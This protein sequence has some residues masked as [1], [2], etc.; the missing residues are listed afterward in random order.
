MK[1]R[2]FQIE[3]KRTQTRISKNDENF[4]PFIQINIHTLLPVSL[5]GSS[6]PSSRENSCPNTD[7]GS[8]LRNK[9]PA[10]ERCLRP[11]AGAGT[12][13][14]LGALLA[15]GGGSARTGAGARTRVGTGAGGAVLGDADAPAANLQPVA[16]LESVLHVRL[17]SELDDP[18]KKKE[19]NVQ[20]LFST[21]RNYE[22]RISIAWYP[23][24][25]S[26]DFSS[27]RDRHNFF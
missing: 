23:D 4:H 2:K 8:S 20:L 22:S 3:K 25:S 16:L 19:E 17:G 5:S 7:D 27:L 11:G 24:G 10:T 6:T 9:V 26:Q 13:A 15:P 1:I 21:F 12:R 18:V 14:G